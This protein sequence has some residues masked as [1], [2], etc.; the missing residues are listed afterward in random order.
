MELESGKTFSREYTSILESGVKREKGAKQ[1]YKK[2]LLKEKKKASHILYEKGYLLAL[3]IG[4]EAF[5]FRLVEIFS[6]IAM[7]I[8]AFCIYGVDNK[9][10]R[11]L[12][13]YSTYYGK[14]ALVQSKCKMIFF[15]SLFLMGT[16]YGGW[17]YSV[18][19]IYSIHPLNFNWNCVAWDA[20]FGIIHTKIGFILFG[21]YGLHLL[22][23]I[24]LG[25]VVGKLTMRGDSVWKK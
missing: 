12:L 24:F 4:D 25:T 7:A 11:R 1:A 9:A 18:S 5:I 6:A 13:L 2:I 16:L 19:R 23:L 8:F 10:E 3:G 17:I 21:F 15:C 14:N 22:A 20:S